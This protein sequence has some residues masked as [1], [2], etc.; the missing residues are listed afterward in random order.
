[1]KQKLHHDERRAGKIEYCIAERPSFRRS[2][3]NIEDKLRQIFDERHDQL[4]DRHSKRA[5]LPP[6][7]AASRLRIDELEP[8]EQVEERRDQRNDADE[9]QTE[10][11][12]APEVS[13]AETAALKA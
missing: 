11:S 13:D 8:I 7:A 2:A 5:A 10:R 1:M 6:W 12:G 3:T 9:R 4:D